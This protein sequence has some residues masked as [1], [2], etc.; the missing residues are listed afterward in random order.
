MLVQ[1]VKKAKR[2]KEEKKMA[3]PKKVYVNHEK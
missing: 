2:E 1:T 3:E